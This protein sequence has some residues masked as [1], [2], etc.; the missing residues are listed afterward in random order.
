MFGRRAARM[1]RPTTPGEEM[2]YSPGMRELPLPLPTNKKDHRIITVPHDPRTVLKYD[3]N[4]YALIWEVQNS[5]GVTGTKV[6][7]TGTG[8]THVGSTFGPGPVKSRTA[9]GSSHTYQTATCAEHTR[10]SPKYFELDP[11]GRP[12]SEK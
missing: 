1:Q 4:E 10:E 7:S 2:M 8:M 5:E 11:Q 6:L 9:D 3:E 12:P